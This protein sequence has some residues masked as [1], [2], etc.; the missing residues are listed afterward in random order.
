MKSFARLLDQLSYQPQRNAKLRLLTDY[1]RNAPDPNRGY[2]LAALTGDL[3][4]RH[5]KASLFRDLAAAR[6]DPVLLGMS[7]ARP[8]W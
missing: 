6:T 3:V 4:F 1:F 2:V 7:W 8:R 5:A